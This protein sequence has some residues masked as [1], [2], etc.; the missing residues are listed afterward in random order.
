MDKIM[1]RVTDLL[2]VAAGDDGMENRLRR[3]LADVADE[4]NNMLPEYEVSL[5]HLDGDDFLSFARP[6]P[7][8]DDWME[9]REELAEAIA[10][11]GDG[12]D[13]TGEEVSDG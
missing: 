10:S 4:L 8:L 7:T 9:E 3:E 2:D 1:V 12:P 11:V 13:P 5:V 6:E